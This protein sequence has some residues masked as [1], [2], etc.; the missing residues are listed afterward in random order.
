MLAPVQVGNIIV[1]KDM[2][3]GVLST[4]DLEPAREQNGTPVEYHE[5]CTSWAEAQWVCDK[6]QHLHKVEKRP[7]KDIAILSRAMK[8]QYFPRADVLGHMK[9]ELIKRGIPHQ[10]T[11]G[12][13]YSSTS[14]SHACCRYTY[15]RC[16]QCSLAPTH[17]MLSELPYIKCEASPVLQ[18]L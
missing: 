18:A 1:Q 6:I 7:W 5:F 9:Q 17:G 11:R 2:S 16:L 14:L 12:K 13:T 3:A 8:S 15:W 10:V 4:K